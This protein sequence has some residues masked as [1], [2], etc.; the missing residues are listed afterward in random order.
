MGKNNIEC[1]LTNMVMIENPKN[2]C[3]VVQNRVKYWKGI[4]FPGG[5]IEKG[6]SFT[7]SVIREAK[8]ETGLDIFN[9]RLCGAVHWCHRDSDRRY[10]VLLYKTTEFSGN[11]LKETE[12]GEVFWT[13]KN[14]IYDFELAPHFDSYLSVF[15]SDK[16]EAFGLYD[17][18]KD[19]PMVIL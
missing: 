12:E 19:D 11:L 13:E 3:V 4:S 16:N 6:E 2:G 5:H 7:D 9:P 1:E 14:R 15:L 17:E 8:E 10:I 18:S